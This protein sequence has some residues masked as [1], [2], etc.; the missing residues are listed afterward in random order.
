[1]S[2]KEK[3]KIE[4]KPKT[5]EDNEEPKVS[6]AWPPMQLIE[7]AEDDEII[8]GGQR[9]D[10]ESKDSEEPKGPLAWPPKRP[11]K[12]SES[13]KTGFG[14]QKPDPEDD[15]IVFG[16]QKPDPESEDN[17]GPKG[18]L[19]WV[20]KKTTNTSGGNTAKGCRKPD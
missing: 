14:G 11:I 17:E 13:D 16:A 18:S 8:F 3:D 9:P 6:I 4:D 5:F 1:M 20:P 7:P 10:P 2:S 19:E 12:S 15:E